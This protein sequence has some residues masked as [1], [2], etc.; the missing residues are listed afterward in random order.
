MRVMKYELQ[1]LFRFPLMWGLLAVFVG[2][3]IYIIHSEV[4]NHEFHDSLHGVYEVIIGHETNG[5]YYEL[6]TQYNDSV[7]GSYDTLD[8]QKIKEMKEKMGDFYPTG[9]YSKFID[10]NYEILQKRVEEI[11]ADGDTDGIFYPG[12]VFQI[13]KKTYL[14]L[15]VCI[16]EMLIMMCFSVLYLM[17]FERLNRTEEL[18]FSSQIGRKD[19]LLKHK[20]GILGGLMFSLLILSLSFAVFGVYVPMR[21]LWSIPVNSVMVMESSGVWEYPFITF[22]PLTIG[23]EFVLSIALTLLL[24]LLFGILSGAVQ[25]YVHNSYITMIDTAVGFVV[26]MLLP[27]IVKNA[28]W[29]KTFVC[30][31]PSSLWYYCSRW[32]IENDLPVSF[33]WSEFITLGIWFVISIILML[34]G[35]SYLKSKDI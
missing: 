6:Y 33:A 19:M 4:G 7:S 17:D 32:F 30:L 28:C 26:F 2:F 24:V 5:E 8:M 29:L 3:N 14:I 15:K 22:V 20:A 27:Y 1:K 21:G 23:K 16:V 10:N 25:L 34:V 13:H 35:K 18:V 12:D 31:T 9:S 11:K